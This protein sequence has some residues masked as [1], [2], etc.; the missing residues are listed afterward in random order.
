MENGSLNVLLKL[1]YALVIHLE[2][3]AHSRRHRGRDSVFGPTLYVH[4][5]LLAYRKVPNTSLS[6]SLSLSPRGD[7]VQAELHCVEQH[8]PYRRCVC[9][10]LSSAYNYATV[11]MGP[12]GSGGI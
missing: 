8:K 12:G 6:L 11:K 7:Y 10:R 1:D 3:F 4:R 2:Q 5:G 9:T